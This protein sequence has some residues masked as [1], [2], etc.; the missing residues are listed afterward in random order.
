MPIYTY[1]T[2]KQ[3]NKRTKEMTMM[4]MMSGGEYWE[5]EKKGRRR[6]ATAIETASIG[7]KGDRATATTAREKGGGGR[8]MTYL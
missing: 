7:N 2:N 5:R 4:T 8:Q 3:T 1:K 6:T